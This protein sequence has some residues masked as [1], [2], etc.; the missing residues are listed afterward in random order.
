[1]LIRVARH[2]LMVLLWSLVAMGI[3]SA[4]LGLFVAAFVGEQSGQQSLGP[5]PLVT[6]ASSTLALVVV[7]RWIERR[8]LPEVGLAGEHAVRDVGLGVLAGVMLLSIVMGLLALT[9]GYSAVWDPASTR[10][11]VLTVVIILFAAWFEEV[12]FRAIIFRHIEG[13][14]GSGAALLVSS[15]FFGT[16]HL[17]NP[18]S[19]WLPSIAIAI[20]AGL[21][22]GAVWMWTRSL[23][24]VWGLHLAWNWTQGGL[25]GAPVSGTPFSGLFRGTLSGD[26]LW[27]GGDF[28]PEAGL[29]AVLVCGTA[30][31]LALVFAV[32]KGAWRPCPWRLFHGRSQPAVTP[33]T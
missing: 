2:P 18:D 27:T 9:G 26:P 30:G 24:A 16:A 31:V 13:W 32:R 1:M 11:I 4:V 7:A 15:L 14:A 19:G 6:A 8:K 21:M 22:L 20:E 3:F 10:D 23:W 28:G 29:V 12:L 5:W 17:G 25:F 33:A